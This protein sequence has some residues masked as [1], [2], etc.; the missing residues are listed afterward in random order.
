MKKI[1]VI[2]G[3]SFIG[4][5]LVT[6]L[7][8]EKD[9]EI[10]LFN[11]GVTNQELFPQLKRII[12]DRNVAADIAQIDAVDWDYVIDVSCYY[13]QSLEWIVNKIKPSVTKYIF[14][15]T[16]SVYDNEVHE[17]M[18]RDESA[19]VVSCTKEEAID[20]TPATYGKRKAACE[21]ILKNGN[22]PFVIL[23]PSLVFG[24]YDPTDRF[25]YWLHQVKTKK[26]IGVPENGLRKF[27][28]TYVGDLVWAI[29]TA[30]HSD[31]EN[32]IYNCISYPLMSIDKIIKKATLL[33]NTEVE[34]INFSAQFLK[35]QNIA[36]WMDIPVWLSSDDYTYTNEKIKLALN[37]KA[38]EFRESMQATIDYF[39]T[40]SFPNPSFGINESTQERLL[41]ASYNEKE[42]D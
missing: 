30:L 18:L 33:C 9:C 10:T 22:I 39:E 1:L 25:Y 5:H 11:R 38:T 34:K 28:L 3:T 15:S 16:A 35:A 42:F 12:G 13:P 6:K 31:K 20:T 7:L 36:E 4:R 17:G 26:Q 40:L 8:G 41:Q 37:F 29:I 19:P 23:R 2:G 27:S 21:E 32:V 24:P 14:V